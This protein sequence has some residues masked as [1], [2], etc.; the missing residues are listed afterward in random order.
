MTDQNDRR[1]A[2]SEQQVPA[3]LGLADLAHRAVAKLCEDSRANDVSD[4]AQKAIGDPMST[5]MAYAL[6]DRE[7]DSAHLI[8]D[9]LLAAG[10]SVEDVCLDHLAPAARRLGEWWE[11][12]KLPFTEVTVATARIQSL[13]RKMPSERAASPRL[14]AK[15][16]FFASVP[17][18]EHTLGVMMA[19]DMFRRNGWDVS[20]LVGQSH[21]ILVSKL[22]RDDRPVI[23]LSC[24]GD[25]S[26]AALKRL[27]TG[28]RK[29]RPDAQILLSGQIVNQPD[30]IAQ[31]P[32]PFRLVTDV[33][34]AE[35]EMAR[36]EQEI[37]SKAAIGFQE[38]RTG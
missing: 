4:D 31:L 13:L 1:S 3:A 2:A 36:V 16:A 21:D 5:A 6:C 19:A 23:G 20:L 15:G 10:L 38:K 35:A 8:V 11:E 7:D 18:E 37:A 9:D 14:T 34:S 24:S 22:S 33:A 32:G 12:D 30:R 25:H 27:M 29:S 28:L 17:G 26:F